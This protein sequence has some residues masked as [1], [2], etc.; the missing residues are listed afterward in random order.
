MIT[1]LA[2]KKFL[3]VFL[4][5]FIL[6][7]AFGN[8]NAQCN[9]DTTVGLGIHPEIPDTGCVGAAYDDTVTFVFPADTVYG[10]F[11]VPFDSFVVGTILNIPPG[12]DFECDQNHPT[13][14]YVTNPPALTRGCVHMFGTPTMANQATD[15]VIVVGSAWITVFGFPV[16]I[17][18]SI[19]ISLRVFEATDPYCG[20][21]STNPLLE[22]QLGLSVYPNPL[23]NTSVLKFHLDHTTDVNIVLNDIYGRTVRNI[24]SG[25]MNPGTKEFALDKTRLQS[26]LYFVRMR[27]GESIIT[28]K[29]IVSQ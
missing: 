13:C 15:S 16:E 25:E 1:Y 29:V 12:M 22:K 11:T 5:A 17:S 8:V 10:G 24:A 19:K 6:F 7:A 20:G 9:P 18:D 3:H 27:V 28:R 2:M 23:E 26:G 14:T 4:F 21:T